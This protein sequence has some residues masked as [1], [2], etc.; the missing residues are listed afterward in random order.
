[1]KAEAAPDEVSTDDLRFWYHVVNSWK[2]IKQKGDYLKAPPR[3]LVT[4]SPYVNDEIGDHFDVSL[5]VNISE[6]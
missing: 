2:L 3:G 5:C 1:M 4:K 6:L